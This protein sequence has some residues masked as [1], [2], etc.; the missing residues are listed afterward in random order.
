MSRLFVPPS[1]AYTLTFTPKA[2]DID[3]NGHVN[4]VV[5]LGWA[6]DLAI[7]HWD[8]WTSPEERA[9]WSWVAR[10]HEVDY[11]RELLPG[12]VAA[13]YTWVGELKGPRFER[14]VRIDGPDGEMCAQ[15]RTDWVLIDIAA[16]R[17]ARV[18]PWMIERF[19][20]K[21]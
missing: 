5:Y 15:A 7:T 21:G 11:R 20:P 3:A 9:P 8:A 2:S 19:T 14:Y 1:D 17:P 4:N 12:E 16:K 13:G 6:Q 10:R 18:L